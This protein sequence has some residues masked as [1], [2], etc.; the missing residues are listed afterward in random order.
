MRGFRLRDFAACDPPWLI[1]KGRLFGSPDPSAVL[2]LDASIDEIIREL[3][4]IRQ[5][6]LS[7]EPTWRQW[8]IQFWPPA[9]RH[10]G[11]DLPGVVVFL[12]HD[13]IEGEALS[14]SSGKLDLDLADANDVNEAA[15]LI[16]AYCRSNFVADLPQAT[17][18][19]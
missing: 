19:S 3:L 16:F 17:L 11:V 7:D 13:E 5:C 12:A 18:D 9:A 14:Q 6:D 4:E 10:G 8:P 1:L 15:Q 2:A